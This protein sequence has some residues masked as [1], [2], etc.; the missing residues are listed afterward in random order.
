MTYDR[1]T[2]CGMEEKMWLGAGGVLWLGGG[3]ER[4]GGWPVIIGWLRGG[5]E[6][7]GEREGEK[8]KGYECEWGSITLVL[9]VF[10]FIV[11]GI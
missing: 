1:G 8:G 7:E 2:P 5:R 6:E 10:P 11:I 4:D 3:E 9:A